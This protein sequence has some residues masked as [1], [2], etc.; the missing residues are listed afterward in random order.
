MPSRRYRQFAKECLDRAAYARRLE[1]R[2]A[3]LLIAEDWLK[4]AGESDV[5]NQQLGASPEVAAAE[6][7]LLG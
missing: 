2:D 4:L 1:D 7:P 6:H 3:W 5:A